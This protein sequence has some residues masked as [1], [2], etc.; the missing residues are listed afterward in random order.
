VFMYHDMIV[1][2]H[3]FKNNADIFVL[4]S[5][6]HLPPFYFSLIRTYCEASTGILIDFYGLDLEDYYDLFSK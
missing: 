6:S 1:I 2:K 3:I 5:F 4:W